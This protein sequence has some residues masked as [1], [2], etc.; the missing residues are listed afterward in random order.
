MQ[1]IGLPRSST[2][3]RGALPRV[4]R[5]A[6]RGAGHRV[7]GH[8]DERAGANAAAAGVPARRSLR[9]QHLARLA[10]TGALREDGAAA[11]A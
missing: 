1:P 5:G 7:G 3:L 8:D 9:A 11:G 6:A 10:A 4:A 2:R